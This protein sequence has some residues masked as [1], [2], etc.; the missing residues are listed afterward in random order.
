MTVVAPP[1]SLVA[2]EALSAVAGGNVETS[3]RIVDAMFSA[4]G[5]AT[6]MP[7]QGQGTMNNLTVGAPGFTY[8]ETL[9]GGQG[10]GPDGDGPSAV[11]VAMSNTRNTPVEVLEVAYPLRVEEYRVRRGTGGAGRHRGGDGVTRRLRVL[12]DAEVSVIAE[13]RRTGPAGAAGGHDGAPGRTALNG[14]ELPAKWRGPV[15]A[16]DELRIDT[17]GGGGWGEVAHPAD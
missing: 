1:G 4:L 11:H 16:G 12:V 7:A 17:P 9:A 15:R 6:P 14:R 8:Y 2:A 10:A 5:Q 3:S 13:R